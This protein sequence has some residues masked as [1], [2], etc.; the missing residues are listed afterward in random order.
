MEK[1]AR[2]AESKYMQAILQARLGNEEQAVRLLP[3]AVGMDVQMR[4]LANLNPELS[5]LV[6]KYG[7]FKEEEEW[8]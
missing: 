8:N 6:K 3:G 2:I 7:L 1:F 5:E 4:F